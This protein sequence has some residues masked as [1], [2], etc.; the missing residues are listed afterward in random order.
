MPIPKP[1]REVLG[2]ATVTAF[3]LFFVLLSVVNLLNHVAMIPSAAWLLLVLAVVGTSCKEEGLRTLL[4]NI[5]GYFASKQFVESISEGTFPVG[6]RFG[7]QLLGHRFV[8]LTIPADKI[9]SVGWHAGQAS[10][11]A[12]RDMKDWYVA[13]WFF[14][15]DPVRSQKRRNM[16][17]PDQGVYCVGPSGPKVDVDAFG[18]S[19]VD[20]LRSSGALLS[21][22]KDE[23]TFVRKATGTETGR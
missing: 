6:I 1:W 5:L 9:T 8:Y 18:R 23:Y 2:A 19:L 3:I 10:S 4:V 20:F 11:F 17:N 15:D 22:G 14:H 16:P 13:V 7:Y 12:G 21:P